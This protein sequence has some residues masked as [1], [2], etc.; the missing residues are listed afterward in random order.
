MSFTRA[1]DTDRKVLADLNDDRDVLAF[2]KVNRYF[3]S[4]CDEKFWEDRFRKMIAHLDQKRLK[5]YKHVENQKRSDMYWKEWHFLVKSFIEFMTEFQASASAISMDSNSER[6]KE[7][8]IKIIRKI[9][10]FYTEKRMLQLYTLSYIPFIRHL[11][12]TA[13]QSFNTVY[14]QAP[15]DLKI[16]K[17]RVDFLEA[18]LYEGL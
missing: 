2:C 3:E 9:C 17:L 12:D 13:I 16:C 11:I 10:A 14:H 7:E 4:L 1:I 6:E 8:K 18:L 15:R 5:I